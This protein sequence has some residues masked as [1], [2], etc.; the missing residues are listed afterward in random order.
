MNYLKPYENI[1]KEKRKKLISIGTNYPTLVP[2]A[3][4]LDRRRWKTGILDTVLEIW[5]VHN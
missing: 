2:T 5:F 1:R 4:K 3:V